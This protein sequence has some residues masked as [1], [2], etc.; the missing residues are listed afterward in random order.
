[1][2]GLGVEIAMTP[3]RSCAPP[4][5]ACSARDSCWR[6]RRQQG[7]GQGDVKELSYTVL[8]SFPRILRLYDPDT[9]RWWAE[10]HLP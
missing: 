1:M 6:W 4:S 5:T 8:A 9:E 7:G 2:S 3:Y 10:T